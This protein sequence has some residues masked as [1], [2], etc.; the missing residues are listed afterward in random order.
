MTDGESWSIEYKL[1]G[2]VIF[3]KQYSWSSGSE[4]KYSHCLTSDQGFPDGNYHVSL[5]VG[6]GNTLLT[7]AD[8][9]VGGGQ[10]AP[11]PSDQGVVTLSGQVV[12][13]DSMNPLPGAE[14]YVLNPGISFDQWKTDQGAMADVFSSAKADSQGNFSV[15]DKLALNVSYTVVFFVDGYKLKVFDNQTFD[16]KTPVNLKLL[17]K[18]TK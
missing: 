2:T 7:Q 9:V 4:G 11:G 10:P 12:D 1:E 8:V 18:M 16:S 13:G 15:P 6:T 5:Y 14:I 3:T 17:I